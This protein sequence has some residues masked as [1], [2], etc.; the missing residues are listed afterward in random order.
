MTTFVF[1]ITITLASFGGEV[2]ATVRT[3]TSDG[4]WKARRAVQT[5]IWDEGIR[6]HVTECAAEETKETQ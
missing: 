2:T 3:T 6:A 4:C 1:V 5:L